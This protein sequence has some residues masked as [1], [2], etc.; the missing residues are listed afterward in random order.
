MNNR[1]SFLSGPSSIIAPILV[2]ALA[3]FLACAFPAGAAQDTGFALQKTAPFAYACIHILGPDPEYVEA[4]GRLMQAIQSQNIHPTGP[5][6]GVYFN[7][8]DM[9]KPADIEWEIGFPVTSQAMPEAPLMKKVWEYK[10][11]AK[12]MHVGPYYKVDET[13]AKL[14]EWIAGQGYTV[15]GPVVERFLDANPNAVKPEEL[16]TEIWIPVKEK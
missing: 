6:M 5:M 10:L 2:F 11:V 15:D 3:A 8:P 4:V 1:R 7:D 16:R 14:R 12:T 13:I 9:V